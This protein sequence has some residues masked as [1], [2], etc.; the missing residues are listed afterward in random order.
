MPQL[1]GFS[2]DGIVKSIKYPSLLGYFIGKM[3]YIQIPDVDHN[4]G[5]IGNSLRCIK[6]ISGVSLT[7]ETIHCTESMF[8]FH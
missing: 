7:R 4:N 6:M 5:Y 8:Y 2:A 3:Y 1:S